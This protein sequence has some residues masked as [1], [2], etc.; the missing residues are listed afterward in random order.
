MLASLPTDPLEQGIEGFCIVNTL[1]CSRI[2]W[3][4]AIS[5]PVLLGRVFLH[6]RWPI[7]PLLVTLT[8]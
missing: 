1:C 7:W 2:S 3:H 4:V 6:A 8:C 5:L